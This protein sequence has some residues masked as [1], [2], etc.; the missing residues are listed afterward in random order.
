MIEER[1]LDSLIERH[2][3]STRFVIRTFKDSATEEELLEYYERARSLGYKESAMMHILE[4]H[5]WEMKEDGYLP[6]KLEQGKDYQ[7]NGALLKGLDDLV[8]RIQI[9]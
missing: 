1:I 8:V 6:V 4:G 9:T 7:R 2:G 3:T 5:G